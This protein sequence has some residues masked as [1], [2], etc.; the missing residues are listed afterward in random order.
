MTLD[1]QLRHTFDAL[2]DR[3]HREIAAY[4]ESATKELIAV[5]EAERTSVAEQIARDVRAEAER[6]ISVRL[7]TTDSLEAVVSAKSVPVRKLGGARGGAVLRALLGR[8]TSGLAAAEEGRPDTDLF[9]SVEV[10]FH[11][12]DESGT[13][14]AQPAAAAPAPR[15]DLVGPAN[16]V[17]A[18][19][20]R[21]RLLEAIRA[22]DQS[23]SLS[24][25]LDTL[26]DRAGREVA[27]A[28]VFLVGGNGSILRSWRC[29]GFGSS[30]GEAKQFE[31]PMDEAG[32]IAEAV[33]SGAAS[34]GD[35]ASSTAPSFALL[36]LDREALA[37]PLPLAGQVVAVLYADTGPSGSPTSGWRT[38]VE[39]LTRYAARSL[40]V[41][42]AFRV[43]RMLTA[44]PDLSERTALTHV[45][46][47]GRADRL[48]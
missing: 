12:E 38:A 25:I 35:G 9:E 23:R 10:G 14:E 28:G 17:V 4:L 7:R 33:R 43:A 13:R 26:V 45:E 20:E 6:E 24:G 5:A 36:P 34:S 19:A 46:S 8:Q 15:V 1:E 18:E 11:E 40:E 22:L 2:S 41:V 48:S 3:L 21:A 44:P 47:R 39:L 29:T 37:V 27:R 30:L 31:V 16:D 42:T 32:V